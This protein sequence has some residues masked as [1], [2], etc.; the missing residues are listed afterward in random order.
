DENRRQ[1]IEK[2]IK[3]LSPDTEIIFIGCGKSYAKESTNSSYIINDGDKSDYVT[4]FKE[5]KASVGNVDAVLYMWPTEDGKWITNPTGIL[6]MLQGLTEAKVQIETILI[7]GGYKDELERCH[8]ESWIGIGR[9][10]GLVMPGT[11]VNIV[12]AN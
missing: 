8:I 5:I 6:Y 11:K 9:S 1:M 7:A 10:T 12:F 4:S 2:S 3:Q